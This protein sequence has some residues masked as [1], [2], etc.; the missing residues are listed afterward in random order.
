ML[1]EALD[2]S[3]LNNYLIAKENNFIKIMRLLNML[4]MVKIINLH[5]KLLN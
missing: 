5:I 1:K 4:L 2:L 3:H